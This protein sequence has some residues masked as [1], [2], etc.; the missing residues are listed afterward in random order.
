M[1][2]RILTLLLILATFSVYLAVGQNDKLDSFFDD[3]IEVYLSFNIENH[4]DLQ[5]ISG[6]VSISS[7]DNETG[8]VKAYA[9]RKELKEFIKLGIEFKKLTPPSMLS[10]DIKMANSRNEMVANNWDSYPT[11]DAY[12]AMMY[13]FQSDYPD[14]CELTN[15]GTTNNGRDILVAKISDNVNTKEAE[16]E[17]LYTSTMHGDEVTGYVLMLR[18]IDYLLTNYGSNPGITEMVNGIEI[19][20]NPNANPDGSYAGGN[21][22]IYGATRYNAMGVDL[23]RNF[24]DPDDGPHPDG[25][26]WQVET[27]AFMDF[28]ENHHF[29]MSSNIHGGAE[30]CNYPWDTWWFTTADDDW[31]QFV[32]REYADTV[33]AYAPAGYLNDLNNGITN[34]YAWYTIAGGRQDY[35][36][37]FHQ[38]REFTLEIS[39]VKMPSASFLPGFWDY[40]YRSF[41]NYI[42]QD[43]FGVRGVV[44]DIDSGDYL[45]AEVYVLNHEAD[46]SWV[47]S[48]IQNGNYHRMLYEGTYDIRFSAPGYW[49]Q[50]FQD[51]NVLNYQAT[52]LNVQLKNTQNGVVSIQEDLFKVFPN[53]VSSDYFQVVLNKA[54]NKLKIYN[55]AG[56]IM[57]SNENVLAG[58]YFVNTSGWEAGIYIIKIIEGNLVSSKKVQVL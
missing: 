41:L 9:N 19:Y 2:Y 5:K 42:K 45:N 11:Y 29:I 40:N 17:F 21:S 50:T 55:A 58:R 43:A 53:P 56:K 14:L 31:W 1:K 35:M 57:F 52:F 33:H 13:Q 22:N 10:S 18:L 37:Y 49:P 47:Y 23:N 39:A 36:N 3:R 25:N 28:A 4:A 24:P 16:P 30:V 46:S 7:Y 20:I 32:C 8:D 44:T 6:I 12:V 51:V 27:K 26:P 48:D 38:C 34:G 15:I 54:V